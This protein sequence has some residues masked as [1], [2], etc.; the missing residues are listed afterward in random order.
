MFE[1]SQGHTITGFTTE[2]SLKKA[3]K[4][5]IV[6]G[7]ARRLGKHIGLGLAGEGFDI[8]LTFNS[9][10][11]AV[12]EETMEQIRSKGAEVHALK[13]DVRSGE[14]IQAAVS[15][16]SERFGPIDVLV[17]NAA[18]FRRVDFGSITERDIDEF[19]MT[20]LASVLLFS[21]E[22][23]QY[24][25]KD[26]GNVSSIINISSMG[27]FENWTGF[28]PYSISKAGVVKLTELLAIKLAPRILVNSIAPGT[29]LIE[30]DQNQNVDMNDVS[31]YPL[32]RFGKTSDIVSLVN[33]LAVKNEFITGQIFKV[34]GGKSLN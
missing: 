22:V 11:Q 27:A 8:A 5:A 21:Q 26:E 32:K 31:K 1:S 33:Y 25:G 10:P 16:I 30:D 13:C 6:T 18:I 14:Q 3:R 15:E 17:N 20:N 2:K 19:I 34:D 4:T 24:M 29:I 7:G 28:I 23:S 12:L 9:T